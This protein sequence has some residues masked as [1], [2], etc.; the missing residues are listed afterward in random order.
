MEYFC[1]GK[2]TS[3]HGIKGTVKVFPTTDD[4]KRFE[5]LKEVIFD[6]RDKKETFTVDKI[7]YQ[8]NMILLTVKEIDDINVAEKYKNASIL[9]PEDLAIPL[10]E[11]EYYARDLYDME[12][13]LEDGT[14]LGV[15]DDILST[16]ANDVYVI[17]R[18]ENPKN[19]ILMPAIKDC[20]KSVN[21]AEKKMTVNLLEGMI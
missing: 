15:I 4:I 18:D 6:I 21:V 16:A 10:E 9:I 3:T 12:V 8:K 19:D 11:D 13:F 14:K 7:Q 2:I 20:I 1:I 5:R 17:K